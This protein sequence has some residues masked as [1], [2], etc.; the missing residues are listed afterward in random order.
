[1]PAAH[2]THP[3]STCAA[4]KG[5]ATP[6]ACAE[7]DKC[8]RAIDLGGGYE[9][10]S[11]SIAAATALYGTIKALPILDDDDRPDEG[12]PQA[13]PLLVAIL[14]EDDDPSDIDETRRLMALAGKTIRDMGRAV[15][16]IRQITRRPGATDDAMREI[17]ELCDAIEQGAWT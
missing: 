14:L 5:C 1:M 8:R 15:A 6:H 2:M 13:M 10:M 11:G 16:E 3:R 9:P 7:E 17:R 12:L 4:A